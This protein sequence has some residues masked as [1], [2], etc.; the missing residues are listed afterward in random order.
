MDNDPETGALTTAFRQ[1]RSVRRTMSLLETKRQRMRD[2]LRQMLLHIGLLVPSTAGTE[3]DWEVL[4]EA[5][6]R[7]G[8]EPFAQLAL[9]ILQEIH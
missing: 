7:L 2:D 5:L 4:Q 1:E 3:I 8:D 6:G 9:Q